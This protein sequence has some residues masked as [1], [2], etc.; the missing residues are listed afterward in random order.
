MGL[1]LIG[2]P[3]AG[4]KAGRTT[5]PATI[6]DAVAALHAKGVE[7]EVWT[8]QGPG[9]ATELARRAVATGFEAVIAAGGDGTVQEV[10]Q[11]LV[12]QNVCLG[13]MPLGSVM[14]LARTLGV[15]RD[16]DAAATVIRR[17]DS[18]AMDVGEV[19][20][21]YFLE[22][23]DVGISA[24]LFPL[25]H[26]LQAGQWSALKAIVRVFFR[27]RPQPLQ[28]TIDG[29]AEMVTAMMVS[30][31][32]VPYFGAG[33]PLHPEAKIDDRSFD[34]QVLQ[35]FSSWDL[36]RFTLQVMH[37]AGPDHPEVRHLRGRR[38]TIASPS[39]IPAHADTHPV[40]TTPITFR[41]V[42]GGLN[43]WVYRPDA[44]VVVPP[45]VATSRRASA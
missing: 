32:I 25:F 14:N 17:R 11:A 2:N 5:N 4:Q 39:P 1:A 12:G 27:Y 20:G 23:A 31:A 10:A 43:V 41:L 16:L 40:G 15:P 34:I 19:N 29:A 8:T 37:G 28:L 45:D 44:S 35:R 21:R 18:V 6:Q 42:P 38:V 3:A 7:V 33:Y 30:V 24:A 36:I 22:V 13:I 26:K 9:D